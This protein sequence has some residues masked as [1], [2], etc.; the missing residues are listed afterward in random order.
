VPLGNEK[1]NPYAGDGA[2]D[3]KAGMKNKFCAKR[4]SFQGISV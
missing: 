3:E 1:G 4:N 2:Q